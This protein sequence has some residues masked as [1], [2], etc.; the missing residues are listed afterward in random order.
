[1]ALV[2]ASVAGS[3]V[4]DSSSWPLAGDRA[5]FS[6]AGGWRY[7]TLVDETYAPVRW[8][9]SGARWHVGFEFPLRA[10]QLRAILDISRVPLELDGH[11]AAGDV[12][13]MAPIEGLS[14]EAISLHLDARRR[15]GRMLG[16]GV[17]VGPFVE[18][19]AEDLGFSGDWD[20][21]D[22]Y[23][24]LLMGPFIRLGW[25]PTA[26]TE[27][28]GSLSIP[29]CGWILRSPWLGSDSGYDW[30]RELQFRS[31][32]S[33]QQVHMEGVVR[34]VMDSD[35]ALEVAA[36]LDWT[37]TGITRPFRSMDLTMRLGL[38]IGM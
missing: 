23:G 9:G 35:T 12:S 36:G 21:S 29:V 18:I 32:G 16:A 8:V 10:T 4:A 28:S 38:V 33:F 1:M 14:C 37:R 24:G 11:S 31:L 26:R 15:V 19:R 27:A 13:Y 22:G 2:I 5:G 6:L 34:R 25:R 30:R 17:E 3:A 20:E 7:A